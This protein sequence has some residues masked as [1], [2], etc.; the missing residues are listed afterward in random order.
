ME[1][2]P[3]PQKMIEEISALTRAPLKLNN[4]LARALTD[5]PEG[6][7][8]LIRDLVAANSAALHATRLMIAIQTRLGEALPL[9]ASLP[10]DW[11]KLEEIIL[12]ATEDALENRR[13]KLIG[14]NGQLARDIEALLPNEIDDDAKLKTLM[15]LVQGARTVFDQKTHRQ[16]KQVF[17]RFN[18]AFHEAQLIEGRGAD[19]LTEAII[20]HLERAEDALQETLGRS[21]FIRISQNATRLADFGDAARIAFGEE[22]LNEA[23]SSLDVEEKETL[24]EAI[25][26][27]V[28]NEV[29]RRLLL[30]AFTEL[31]V[32]Y[33]TK[34]EALRVSIGLEAY[35][36][37][38]PLVQYKTQASESFQQ[39]LKDVRGLVIGRLFAIQ[40]R[41]VEIA[42][43]EVAD[44]PA[45][46]APRLSDAGAKK[47]KRRRH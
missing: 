22:K 6:A 15:S 3:R 38:D 28:V 42:P 25:G 43:V 35:A 10:A 44:T 23:P 9:S 34:I 21:E 32:E 47:K 5:D 46:T 39:L 27:Y 2:T 4:D 7:K 13:E 1:E 45:T 20:K 8:E 12:D 40:P 17:N 11:E 18:Y 14:A 24:I 16:V 19:E 30:G 26:R 31:W 37:R 29:Q 33:L 41:R 36:Q